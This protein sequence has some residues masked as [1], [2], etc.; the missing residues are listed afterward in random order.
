MVF[1]GCD[2]QAPGTDVGAVDHHIFGWDGDLGQLGGDLPAPGSVAMECAAVLGTCRLCL[3]VLSEEPSE[4]GAELMLL[5]DV[6]ASA[7]AG[8]AAGGA[9]PAP[10]AGSVFPVLHEFGAA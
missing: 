2:Q 9:F 7:G 8:S 6:F 4:E 3:G 10:R 5:G 1:I